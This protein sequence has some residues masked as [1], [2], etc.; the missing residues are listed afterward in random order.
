MTASN[1]LEGRVA[2]ETGLTIQQAIVEV[3]IQDAVT[4]SIAAAIESELSKHPRHRIVSLTLT[5]S[6]EFNTSAIALIVIEYLAE[7]EN[8]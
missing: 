5:A 6:R 1:R 8:A 3:K 2:L 4:S 7:S